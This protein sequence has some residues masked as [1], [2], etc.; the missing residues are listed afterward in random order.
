ML[1][2]I[3]LVILLL[4]INLVFV[5]SAARVECLDGDSIAVFRW[6]FKPACRSELVD[7]LIGT[8]TV[9]GRLSALV[10]RG[11]ALVDARESGSGGLIGVFG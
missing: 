6:V 5:C 4:V 9:L 3:V 1:Q 11:S 10:P 7:H 8:A 2:L